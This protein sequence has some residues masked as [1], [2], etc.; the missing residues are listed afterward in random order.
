M[1][2]KST[3]SCCPMSKRVQMLGCLRVETVRAE[4]A[5]GDHGHGV[6]SRGC[7]EIVALDPFVPMRGD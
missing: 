5:S 7:W 6:T 1:T 4:L 3:R 2:R